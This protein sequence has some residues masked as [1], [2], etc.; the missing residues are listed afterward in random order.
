M[1]AEENTRLRR[2]DRR[3]FY[4]WELDEATLRA[5]EEAEVPEEARAFDHE[6]EPE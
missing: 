6:V 4:A 1:T 3:A 5:I 2:G